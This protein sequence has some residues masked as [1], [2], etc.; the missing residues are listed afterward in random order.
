MT[1]DRPTVIMERLIQEV[2]RGSA[3][4]R[5]ELLARASARLEILISRQLRA[6]PK[7]HRWE[8]TQDVLQNV[9]MRLVKVLQDVPLTDVK[10]FMAMSGLAIRRELIDLKRHYFGPEGMGAHHATDVGRPQQTDFVPRAENA[11][12]DTLDPS[13]LAW[14]TEFHEKVSQMPAELLEVM[15]LLWYQG[16]SQEEAA[17]LL[18][19]STKTI[20]R[21]WREA[22]IELGKWMND[23]RLQED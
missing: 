21:R 20:G 5:D 22:R 11:A 18:G 1:E 19:V 10:H 15:N 2:N 7:V 16:L 9:L 3:K 14:W 6:F 4:A 12:T 17:E 8:D 13:Q 23:S